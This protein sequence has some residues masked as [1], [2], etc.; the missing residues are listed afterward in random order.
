MRMMRWL[1]VFGVVVLGAVAVGGVSGCATARPVDEGFDVGR[2]L[3]RAEA[4]LE[5]TELALR[6]WDEQAAEHPEI[7]KWQEERD[8]LAAAVKEARAVVVMLRRL[9]GA[10]A[11]GA[12]P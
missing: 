3:A 8:R 4:A 5:V 10:R 2:A 9:H 11:D 7:D 1:A 6:V 12:R